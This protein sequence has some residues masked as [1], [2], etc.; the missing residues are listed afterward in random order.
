MLDEQELNDFFRGKLEAVYRAIGDIMELENSIIFEQFLENI[1]KGT[2]LFLITNLETK[3]LNKITDNLFELLDLSENSVAKLISAKKI[4]EKVLSISMDDI[5]K[6]FTKELSDSVNGFIAFFDLIGDKRFF[7]EMAIIVLVISIE[8]YLKDTILEIC[9]RERKYSKIIVKNLRGKLGINRV[10]DKAFDSV[11]EGKDLLKEVMMYIPISEP[12]KF[13]KWMMDIFGYS[14]F[15][16]NKEH[17]QYYRKA[18]ALR[19]NFIHR[20]GI[21]DEKLIREIHCRYK[22]GKQYVIKKPEVRQ[23][24]LHCLRIIEQFEEWKCGKFE[25]DIKV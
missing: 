9:R 18:F 2:S 21:V 1:M 11:L 7:S 8:V 22:E 10:I 17:K 14:K 15:F 13:N 20:N 25:V 6:R 5:K 24:Y 16:I 19:H 23:C 12:N 4:E 3:Q